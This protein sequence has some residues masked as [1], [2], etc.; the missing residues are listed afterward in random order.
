MNG[1]P[2]HPVVVHLPLVLAFL[3]PLVAASMLI[4]RWRGKA[5]R[6]AWW[7]VTVV[8]GVLAAGTWA[9]VQT[10]EEDEEAVEAVVAEEAIHQHEERG[11]VLLWMSAA[12]VALMLVVPIVGTSLQRAAGLAAVAGSLGLAVTAW[13]VG[14]SG[15]E[16]VYRHGAANAYVQAASRVPVGHD[17]AF[18]Q[19]G[20]RDDDDDDERR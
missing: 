14:H 20:D 5:P 8:A 7:I 12:Y 3:M 18:P 9:A 10:G 6:R 16:L 17:D 13:L 11:E 4:A 2:L 15:G 19:R 1:L